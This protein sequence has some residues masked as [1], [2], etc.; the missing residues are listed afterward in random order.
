MSDNGDAAEGKEEV[1]GPSAEEIQSLKERSGQLDQYKEIGEL[2]NRYGVDPKAYAEQSEGAFRVIENL[3]SQGVIDANGEVVRK[4]PATPSAPS[5]P[6]P[7]TVPAGA[8]SEQKFQDLMHKA[9]NPMVLE[10]EK[11]MTLLQ[12]HNEQLTQAFLADKIKTQYQDLDTA[13]IAKAM[14]LTRDPNNTRTVQEIAKEISDEKKV[15]QGKSRKQYAE[16]FG[17]DLE[18]F[19]QNKLNESGDGGGIAAVVGDN[20]LSFKKGEK[21]GI[22]PKD[23]LMKFMR[24][25]RAG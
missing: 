22:T 6:T 17:I 10:M 11:K 9:L 4:A 12:Q 24:M 25:K 7:T 21:G 1:T 23:A 3:M 2:A 14:T 8:P 15:S 19:D 5:A 16:E 13:D 18:E 20:K